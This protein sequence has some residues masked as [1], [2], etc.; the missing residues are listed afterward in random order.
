LN[1]A[2]LFNTDANAKGKAP[3]DLIDTPLHK[4]ADEV[5]SWPDI[6]LFPRFS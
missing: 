6:D 3:A 5:K 4:A 2:V 1:W